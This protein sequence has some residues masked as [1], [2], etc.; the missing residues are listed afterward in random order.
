MSNELVNRKNIQWFP[1]HMMKTLRMIEA[2]IKNVDVVLQLLD[3]RIPFSSINPE[4][5]DYCAS[6]PKLFVLNKADLADPII[7]EQWV[8]YFRENNIGCVAISSKNKNS[9][10]SVRNEIDKELQ[11][12][13]EKR[14]RKGTQGSKIRMMIVGIPN[15][16]KSTFI[17][18]FTGTN[19]ARAADKPGV[20]RGKQ[21]VSTEKYDLLDMPGVLW[22]K[23]ESIEIATNL[24]FIGSIKDDILDIEEIACSLLG[25]VKKLYANALIQRFK[26]SQEDLEVSNY[27]L[28]EKIGRKRG[29]LISK[30]EINTERAAIMV[31]D[32]FRASKFGRITFETPSE[33][34][35]ERL[36]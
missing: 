3:S 4:I 21:W 13:L 6:K 20:T 10:K 33:E 16:G 1:G 27:E 18:T 5:L 11:E 17:N 7:T 19:K 23:F 28:L 2:D 30:G 26:L 15:V 35:N 9:V 24:A 36:I 31:C 12:L 32:E 25:Q 29:M 14:Q 22:K 34:L 8:K